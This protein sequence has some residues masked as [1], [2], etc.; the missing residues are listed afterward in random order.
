MG[1]SVVAVALLAALGRTEDLGDFMS[2]TTAIGKAM[3]EARKKEIEAGQESLVV[4][5]RE[6]L[7]QYQEQQNASV[8]NVR[9]QRRRVQE[10]LNRIKERERAMHYCVEVGNPIPLASI[11]GLSN[12]TFGLSFD[13]WAELKEIPD[14]W[15]PQASSDSD[16]GSNE[17]GDE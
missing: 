11:L 3:A 6:V 13:E 4:V 2:N 8:L 7:S 14:D 1:K 9:E 12:H 10:T 17:G 16:A 15:A 5:C